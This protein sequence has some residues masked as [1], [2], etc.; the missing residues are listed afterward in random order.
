M[1][2]DEHEKYFYEY[3]TKTPTRVHTPTKLNLNLVSQTVY[4]IPLSLPPLAEILRIQYY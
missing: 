2:P 3:V 4:F 1:N